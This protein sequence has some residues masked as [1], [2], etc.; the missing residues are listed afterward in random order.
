[1]TTRYKPNVEDIHIS[2]KAQTNACFLERNLTKRYKPNVEQIHQSSKVDC[3]NQS[4]YS[5]VRKDGTSC[6]L[7]Q[8]ATLP[9]GQS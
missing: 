9:F 5:C 6:Q 4:G 2:S 3:M 7:S 1:M 8:R